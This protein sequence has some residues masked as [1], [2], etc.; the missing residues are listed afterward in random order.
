[1]PQF[2]PDVDSLLKRRI[3]TKPQETFEV[4]PVPPN[5][6]ESVPTTPK[7]EFSIPQQP[8]SKRLETEAAKVQDIINIL[9]DTS[10]EVSVP[11][12]E[13][14][15]PFIGATIST[16]DYL[17]SLEAT[18]DEDPLKHKKQSAYEWGVVNDT[19]DTPHWPIL[20][21]PDL[22]DIRNSLLSSRDTIEGKTTGT[23]TVVNTETWS[24][25][26]TD[27]DLRHVYENSIHNSSVHRFRLAQAIYTFNANLNGGLIDHI[28][29]QVLQKEV[30][31]V[32]KT[33]QDII[34]FLNTARSLLTHSQ[35]ILSFEFQRSRGSVLN[36]IENS[37]ISQLTH[38]LVTK[39]SKTVDGL[40]SPLFNTLENGL[41]SGSLLDHLPDDVSRQFVSMLAGTSQAIVGQYKKTAADLLRSSNNKHSGQLDNLQY[42]GER[43]VASRWIKQ[44]DHMV[45]V[46]KK[47]Q[48]STTLSPTLIK[49]SVNS[50]K[51]TLPSPILSLLSRFDS[52]PELSQASNI[53]LEVRTIGKIFAP[54]P[55][56]IPTFGTDLPP[57]DAQFDFD[58]TNPAP[59]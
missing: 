51:A 35:L 23:S 20:V 32:R 58:N 17:K 29:D 56:V 26:V 28:L 9:I 40:V 30:A 21:I 48:S 52:H 24:S 13:E 41:G 6:V 12:P 34:G 7:T 27:S 5:P 57:N 50:A 4:G 59:F 39:L 49:D 18:D 33:L 2:V 38:I 19:G 42:L 54:A 10:S 53:P 22:I 46:L 31:E 36:S 11:V 44:I 43:N 8:I 37:I 55:S 45:S 16:T 47:L 15:Q 1:M 25:D 3:I 14:D